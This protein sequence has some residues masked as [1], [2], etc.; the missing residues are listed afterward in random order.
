MCRGPPS[1]SLAPWD[2]FPP[3]LAPSLPHRDGELPPLLQL[4][5][6]P[7]SLIAR[8]TL[9]EGEERG[10]VAEGVCL[11]GGSGVM[12]MKGGTSSGTWQ[13][14]AP[15]IRIRGLDIALSRQPLHQKLTNRPTALPQTQT[16]LMGP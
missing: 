4:W 10:G 8:V 14:K 7:T 2:H 3:L 16:G 12:T 5:A 11:G 9:G 15:K 1:A 13:G 6:S